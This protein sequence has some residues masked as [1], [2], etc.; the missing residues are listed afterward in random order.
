MTVRLVV[1]AGPHVGK[2]F[3]FDRHDTFLVGRTKDAHL[4]LSYDD[5]YFSRRHF[6]VEVN[7]PRVRVIDLQSRN[8]S[9]VN[10]QRVE[11]AELRN[12]DEIRAGHTVFRVLVPTPD[13]EEQRT[14]DLPPDGPPSWQRAEGTATFRGSTNLPG[15]TLG[16]ELGRGGMGVVYR[17]V[18]V[19]DGA[20]VAVKMITPS[21]GVS[22]KQIKRFIREA[23]VTAAL[24]HPHV[25]Q[26][27]D[28]GTVDGV[29]FLVM[30]L[31][32]GPDAARLLEMKGPLSIPTAV[33]I[34]CQMLVGLGHAH[35]KGFVHRDIKPSNLLIGG[36]SGKRTV[37]VADFG[38]AR[39]Y[40]ECNLSGLTMQGEVAGTPAYMA[41]EQVTHFRE[42]KPAA[43]QYSAAATLYA[44]LTGSTPIDMP[45]DMA[46]QIAAVV[47]SDPV[48]IGEHRAE[49]PV[50]L[51]EAVHTALARDPASRF[52]NVDA[53]R[54][55]L[56]PFAS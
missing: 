42:V 17:G 40:D 12:G 10:G 27:L 11:S 22:S 33:R 31:I 45:K 9:H 49:V 50:G 1:T 51:S 44:L 41:P 20:T 34:A 35:G 28:S 38:L 48:P 43:D 8:G 6:L 14:L 7:P 25:V 56:V 55:A 15:Y 29:V 47:N 18:R 36:A 23:E 46:R 5:P 53:F 21:A 54:A 30:E 13:P 37:K 16:A 24:A 39:A 32:E 3:A 26:H 52:S 2:E 19:A 4:Q